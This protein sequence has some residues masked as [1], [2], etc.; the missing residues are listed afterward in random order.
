M[1]TESDDTPAAERQ[2]FRRSVDREVEDEIAFHLAMR[3][4]EA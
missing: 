4:R 3:A 1:S 2:V